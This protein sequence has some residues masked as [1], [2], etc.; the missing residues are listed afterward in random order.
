MARKTIRLTE[1]DLISFLEPA[2]QSAGY[3]SEDM[4]IEGLA[5][6]TRKIKKDGD[7]YKDVINDPL[8][9]SDVEHVVL[10]KVIA[11]THRDGQL[12]RDN[13]VGGEGGE[14]QEA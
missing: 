14:E 9:T 11:K 10:L 2:L 6:S 7:F 13:G 12:P 3:L 8:V 5:Y 1:D 4:K